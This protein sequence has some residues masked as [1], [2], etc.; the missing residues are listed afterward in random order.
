[1]LPVE[2]LFQPTRRPLAAVS[3]VVVR[4]VIRCRPS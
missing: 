1:M 4:A 3:F 2:A